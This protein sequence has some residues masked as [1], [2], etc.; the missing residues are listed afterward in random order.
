MEILIEMAD[1]VKKE[2][3]VTDSFIMN[4]F[5]FGHGPKP[6]VILPGISLL[7]VMNFA[8]A[9]ADAYKV[10]TDDYTI[11][12]FEPQNEITESFSIREVMDDTIEA[13]RM[14]GL[15]KVTLMGASYGGMT[16]MM[17]AAEHPEQVEN[18]ILCGTSA[19]VS[20]ERYRIF[21]HWISLVDEGDAEALYQDFGKIVYPHSI[22]EQS[23]DVLS[24]MAKGV[25]ADDMDR[26]RHHLESIR[27]FDV[28]ESLNKIDSRVFI[29]SS[30]DDMVFGTEGPQSIADN[31]VSCPKLKI[32]I[33]DGCGHA[34][35]DTAPDLKERILRFL[36]NEDDQEEK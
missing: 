15:G 23:K 25:T 17:L 7:S 28:R 35:Y 12:V 26:F 29:V 1:D 4:Y 32:K 14:L 16:S 36:K 10:L 34:V 18:L 21:E 5:R 30:S 2:K 11:Y 6:F 22:Y 24:E 19:Y 20:D 31:M 3:V 33:Y 13:L 9:V 8:D 27:G